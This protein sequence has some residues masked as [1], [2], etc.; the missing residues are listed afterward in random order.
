MRLDVISIDVHFLSSV[1]DKVYPVDKSVNFNF[2]NKLL[3]CWI[4]LQNKIKLCYL[5]VSIKLNYNIM[6]LQ[7]SIMH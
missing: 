7:M 6:Y 4:H 5:Y 1:L 2:T 3:L